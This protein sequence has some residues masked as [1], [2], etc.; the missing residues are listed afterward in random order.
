VKAIAETSERQQLGTKVRQKP[1]SA[2]R[3]G[4]L[5]P[6]MTERPV[7]TGRLRFGMTKTCRSVKGADKR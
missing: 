1:T 6:T 3:S 5:F 4:H 2:R 7:T